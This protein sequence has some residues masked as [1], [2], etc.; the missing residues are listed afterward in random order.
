[1]IEDD[2]GGT[3]KV[4][5]SEGRSFQRRG[6]VVHLVVHLPSLKELKGLILLNCLGLLL[7]LICV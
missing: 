3:E 2:G 4:R 5:N 6:A 7:A 1:M